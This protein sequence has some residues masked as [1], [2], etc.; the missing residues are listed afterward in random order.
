MPLAFPQRAAQPATERAPVAIDL[1]AIARRLAPQAAAFAAASPFPHLVLDDFLPA[2][3]ADA[4]A[5][6][7]DDPAIAWQPLHHVNERKS[8][9]GDL[10]RMGPVAATTVRTLYSP[11]MCA[12]LERLT[13]I[14]QLIGDPELDGAG[15]HRTDPGGHLNVHTDALAHGK[16]R[17]WSRQLNL[18]VFLNRD[19][20]DAYRGELELWDADVSRCVQRIAPLFNRCVLFRTTPVSYHG[21][22]DAVACPE[23]RS[24]KSL[25]LYYF[26]DEARVVPLHPTHYVPRPRDPLARRVLIRADRALLRLYALLKRYTPIDD[27]R[28]TRLLRRF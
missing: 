22:P 7:F 12:T 20:S 13:G 3:V 1:D 11:A 24:R 14:T 26:R 25:A 18:I 8:V 5:A 9:F 16:R 21:V 27:A 15:L 2:D 28:V 4:L 19:W 23:G 17:T 10:A 6:E